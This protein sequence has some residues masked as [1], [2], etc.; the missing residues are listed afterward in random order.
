M[1]TSIEKP[2]RRFFDC[3][4]QGFAQ[5]DFEK[6]GTIRINQSK[7]SVMKVATLALFMV[8]LAHGVSAQAVTINAF[9]PPATIELSI[10]LPDT[11]SVLEVKVE[12]FN[13][14]GGMLLEKNISVTD[15]SMSVSLPISDLEKGRYM[16]RT[17]AGKKVTTLQFSKQ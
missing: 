3:P 6:R 4:G 2:L 14:I 5:S 17:T 11:S 1:K 15:K 16:I 12:L 8:A 7:H 10:V 13:L 9:S